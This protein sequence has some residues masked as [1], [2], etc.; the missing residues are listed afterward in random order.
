MFSTIDLIDYVNVY[1]VYMISVSTCGDINTLFWYALQ[2][3]TYR[4]LPTCGIIV[5][6]ELMITFHTVLQKSD[7]L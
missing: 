1:V 6:T 2:C 5:S 3:I 7:W 4:W